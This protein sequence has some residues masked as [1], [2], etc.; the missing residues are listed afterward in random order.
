MDHKHIRSKRTTR[1][2]LYERQCRRDARKLDEINRAKLF[3]NNLATAIKKS[4][5]TM[6]EVEK[7][8]LIDSA[9]LYNYTRGITSPKAY[10]VAIL[11]KV[12]K[13]SFWELYPL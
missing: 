13:S 4:G 2:T 9:T 3:G 5:L 10:N 6:R 7:R 11:A 8:T 12:L 1:E